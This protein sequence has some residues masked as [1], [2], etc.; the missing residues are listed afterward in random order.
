MKFRS[1]TRVLSGM[2]RSIKQN[3]IK[4]GWIDS[5]DHWMNPGVP[6]AQ[7]AANLYYD[8]PWGGLNNTLIYDRWHVDQ[9]RSILSKDLKL[10]GAGT[11]R[12]VL[13]IT[14]EHL[15]Q[16]LVRNIVETD[17]PSNSG[18][19]ADWKGFN[20]PLQYGSLT[21]ETPNLISEVTYKVG[22]W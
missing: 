18:W 20:K 13:N 15:Q 10:L 8:S 14:G 7:V 9:I 22:K 12:E 16:Q 6:V 11:F 21:G 4:V 19:W 3:K 17:S 5:K 1:N 2:I